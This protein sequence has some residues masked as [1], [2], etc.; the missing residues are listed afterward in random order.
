MYHFVWWQ[1]LVVIKTLSVVA[2]L[3][4][5]WYNLISYKMSYSVI[6]KGKGC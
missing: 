6:E 3:G 1:H 5:R 4:V 2:C